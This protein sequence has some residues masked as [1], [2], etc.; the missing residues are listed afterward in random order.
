[1]TVCASIPALSFTGFFPTMQL[2]STSQFYIEEPV[3][4]DRSVRTDSELQPVWLGQLWLV[5][6]VR[7]VGEIAVRGWRIAVRCETPRSEEG[8]VLVIFAISFSALLGFAALAVDLGN[9]AQS[10][11]NTQN[12]ADA[13]ALAGVTALHNGADVM[14]AIK[15]VEGV[16]KTYI[17][18]ISWNA[19]SNGCSRPAPFEACDATNCIA[20]Y[21]NA[22]TPPR[23]GSRYPD[24]RYPRSSATPVSVSVTA[25]AE[26]TIRS[27]TSA[28]L[29]WGAPGSAGNQ[30][31]QGNC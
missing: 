22:M 24:R 5:E 1:M 20:F 9:T 21:P 4:N 3:P 12:A 26:A 6:P 29:C 2:V 27:T 25:Y 19:P 15:S 17:P 31:N 10:H 7:A 18:D 11:L 30:G 8:A 28:K 23:S 16:A 13:A 14:S